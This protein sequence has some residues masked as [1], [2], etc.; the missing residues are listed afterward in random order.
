[1]L[2]RVFTMEPLPDGLST[3]ARV[4]SRLSLTAVVPAT[5]HQDSLARCL[6]AIRQ[7][8]YPS[9]EPCKSASPSKVVESMQRPRRTRYAAGD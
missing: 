7:A 9:V 6:Q 1:M 8:A 5:D 4:P 2:P 3:M